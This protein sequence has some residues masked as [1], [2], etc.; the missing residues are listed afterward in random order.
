MTAVIV[1]T[2]FMIVV[3]FV[4]RVFSPLGNCEANDPE[5]KHAACHKVIFEFKF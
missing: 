3:H 2:F 1:S 4:V 5:E